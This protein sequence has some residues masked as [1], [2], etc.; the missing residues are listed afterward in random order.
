[1]HSVKAPNSSKEQMNNI[2]NNSKPKEDKRKHVICLL[3][4][5][6]FAFKK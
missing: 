2:T 1:M 3:C 5:A 6:L 4:R